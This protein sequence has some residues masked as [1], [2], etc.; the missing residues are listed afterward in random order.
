MVTSLYSALSCYIGAAWD[1]GVF[2][3][4]CTWA[5]THMGVLGRGVGGARIGNILLNYID[6]AL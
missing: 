5:V 4:I 2:T 6:T 3:G 1:S